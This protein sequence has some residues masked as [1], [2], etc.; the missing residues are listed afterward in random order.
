MAERDPVLA[1]PL[2][3]EK[4]LAPVRGE[5]GGLVRGRVVLLIGEDDQDVRASHAW[6]FTPTLCRPHRPKWVRRLARLTAVLGEINRGGSR[7]EA[8]VEPPLRQRC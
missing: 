2:H 5:L 6:I 8:W 1:Q 4:M 3:A 7:C